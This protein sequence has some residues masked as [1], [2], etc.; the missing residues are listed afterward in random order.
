MRK[1]SQTLRQAFGECA[2]MPRFLICMRCFHVI[3][4]LRAAQRENA[5]NVLKI[6]SR[7]IEN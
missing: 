3:D 5:A 2:T 7:Q 4:C 6:C 1:A